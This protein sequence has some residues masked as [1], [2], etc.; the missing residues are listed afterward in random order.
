MGPIRV[1]DCDSQL[2]LFPAPKFT[3][4]SIMPKDS[5]EKR[6]KKEKKERKEKKK[7]E[8]VEEAPVEPS[9]TDVPEGVEMDGVEDTKVGFSRSHPGLP[10]TD[11]THVHQ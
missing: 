2:L 4:S 6:E 9:T 7:R 8:V 11:Q 5:T 10:P 1:I 3:L